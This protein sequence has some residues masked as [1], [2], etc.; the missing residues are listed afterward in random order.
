VV[1]C[2]KSSYIC[3]NRKGKRVNRE[4]DHE[5]D[6]RPLGHSRF[7]LFS[8]KLIGQLVDWLICKPTKKI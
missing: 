5:A 3:G 6:R 8:N 1:E 2:G 7:T 4:L